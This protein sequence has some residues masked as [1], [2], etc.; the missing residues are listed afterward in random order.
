[1]ETTMEL[2][3]LKQAWQALGRQL[4]RQETIDLALLRERKLERARGRLR[5]LF[6]GQ[7][8]QMLFGVAFI[9]LG[10]A[11]WTQHSDVPHLLLAG[12]V[13][14]VYGVVTVAMAGGTLG[15]VAR[16]DYSAP[17][18]AIQKRLAALRRFYLINGMTVGLP[19]WLLYV[20]VLMALAALGGKDI[21]AGG[22][23]WVWICLAVGI[24][25]LLGTWIF[26]R[27]SRNPSRAALG[28]RLDDGAAGGGIRRVQATLDEIAQFE[29]D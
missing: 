1:M 16:I 18:L 5:P 22:A 20:P 27:W 29:R 14:H 19:W 6:W 13:L 4:E 28:R 9:L 24:A 10:V 8:M 21:Y 15:L 26:H 11:C 7:I 3:Q 12:I 25:G 23:L 2:D 17:V